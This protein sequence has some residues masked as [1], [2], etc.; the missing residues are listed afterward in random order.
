VARDAR[1]LALLLVLTLSAVVLI[2]TSWPE[3]D[4]ISRLQTEENDEA[5]EA[6]P[7]SGVPDEG[8]R[9]ARH[10]AEAYFSTSSNSAAARGKRLEPYSSDALTEE[11]QINSGALALRNSTARAPSEA[12]VIA[13]QAQDGTGGNALVAI[14]EH[15]TR[16]GGRTTTELVTV[17]LELVEEDGEWLVAEVLVP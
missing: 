6:T 16:S 14:V 17:T 15:S 5:V 8:R 12:E 2:V 13:L 3:H 4:D 11:M 9:V 1:L 7:S 10:F